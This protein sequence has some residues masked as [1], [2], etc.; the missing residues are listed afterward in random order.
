VIESGFGECAQVDGRQPVI[1]VR[2]ESLGL[3]VCLMRQQPIPKP[4]PLGYRLVDQRFAGWVDHIERLLCLRRDLIWGWLTALSPDG[5]DSERISEGWVKVGGGGIHLRRGE[6][7]FESGSRH[8]SPLKDHSK[9][10]G[11]QSVLFFVPQKQEGKKY[12]RC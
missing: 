1:L 6:G 10:V 12:R 8:V 3:A 9:A 5:V 2:G 11:N 4:F 7:P